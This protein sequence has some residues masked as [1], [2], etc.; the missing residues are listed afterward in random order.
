MESSRNVALNFLKS[1]FDPS[2][3]EFLTLRLVGIVYSVAIVAG[4]LTAL[5][6]IIDAFVSEFQSGLL[7]LIVSPITFVISILVLRVILETVVVA[8]RI[9]DNTAQ[10]ARNTGD[11]SSPSASEGSSE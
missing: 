5:A 6:K 9:A 1:L 8:F 11:S 2:F 10:I 3:S 4:A 7:A